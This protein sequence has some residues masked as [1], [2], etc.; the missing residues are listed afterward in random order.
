MAKTFKQFLTEKMSYDDA[1]RIMG[2]NRGFS[3]DEL[4]QRRKKLAIQYHPDRG[5]DLQKMQDVNAAYDVLSK[6]APSTGGATYSRSDYA[7]TRARTAA[8]AQIALDALLAHVQPDNFKR[9]FEKIFNE[10]FTTRERI[11]DPKKVMGHSVSASYTFANASQSTVMYVT[12]TLDFISMY[13]KPVLSAEDAGFQVSVWSEILSNRRKVKL[14][15][16]NYMWGESY[17]VVHDPEIAFP[18]SKLKTKSSTAKNRKMSRRDVELAITRELNGTLSGEWAYIPIGGG[19][20]FIMWRGTFLGKAHW[21]PHQVKGPNSSGGRADLK[22]A[23]IPE[24][25]RNINAL[26]DGLKAMQR[27]NIDDEITLRQRIERLIASVDYKAMP[28]E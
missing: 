22:H 6:S 10:P 15:Q 18:A 27:Q 5:G 14:H 1:I 23:T 13:G 11:D 24:L 8:Y 21:T 28:W 4:D 16:R 3:K 12:F 9:H 26:F 7:E 2:L 17:K 25:E 19:F 20:K